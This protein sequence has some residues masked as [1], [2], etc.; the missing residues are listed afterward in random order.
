MN[1][2]P[3]TYM[4]KKIKSVS[5]FTHNR[6]SSKLLTLKLLILDDN[7]VMIE[8]TIISLKVS[9]RNHTVVHTKK[10]L[11]SFGCSFS[12]VRNPYLH[13]HC[14]CADLNSIFLKVKLNQDINTNNNPSEVIG[15]YY[16]IRFILYSSPEI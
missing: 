13:K 14:V 2:N 10:S 11:Y 1:R 8:K 7:T 12:T 9:N 16:L 4:I 3:I 15:L 5:K 6:S